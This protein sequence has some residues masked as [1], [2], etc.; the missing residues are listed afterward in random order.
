MSKREFE[1][2]KF[3]LEKD[4][5]SHH[6]VTDR[7]P[8]RS[9]DEY[10]VDPAKSVTHHQYLPGG[11]ESAGTKKLSSAEGGPGLTTWAYGPLTE[12]RGEPPSSLAMVMTPLATAVLTA[13]VMLTCLALPVGIS[14]VIINP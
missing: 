5:L 9:A 13:A 8:R 3:N 4:L 1:R 7:I 2:S 11:R 14:I 12:I 6:G 10:G